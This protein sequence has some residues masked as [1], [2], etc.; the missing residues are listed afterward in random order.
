MQWIGGDQP[1]W[2]WKMITKGLDDDDRN[3][4]DLFIPR[5]ATWPIWKCN[6]SSASFAPP[7]PYAAATMGSMNRMKQIQPH[8]F[9]IQY[10]YWCATAFITCNSRLIQQQFFQN[11][12]QLSH[13][14][15][16]LY[17]KLIET[18]VAD[19]VEFAKF[20][21]VALQKS[22]VDLGREMLEH[23]LGIARRW[24]HSELL[25]LQ[26]TQETFRV[27]HTTSLSK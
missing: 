11:V 9:L 14:T 1:Q 17:D 21:L 25:Y 7:S 23:A 19:A 10:L 27:W 18:P 4:S 26:H 20:S 12:W 5:A 22:D 13:K 3:V 8:P 16:H 24:Y 6:I 2:W 15:N